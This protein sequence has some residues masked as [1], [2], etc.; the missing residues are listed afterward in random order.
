M[1]GNS[2][3][4]EDNLPHPVGQLSWNDLQSF[5]TK[6]NAGQNYR[7]QFALPSEAQ[8][9][10]ACRAGTTTLWHCGNSEKSARESCWFRG[11]SGGGP[12]PVGQYKANAWGLFDM[13]GNVTEWCADR[14]D[15]D[16]YWQSPVEDP[17]GPQKGNARVHRGGSW[18]D[19]VETSRSAYRG[20]WS[21]NHGLDHFGFRLA[22]SIELPK[23]QA[24]MPSADCV[25]LVNFDDPTTTLCPNMSLDTTNIEASKGASEVAIDSSDGALGSPMSLR[26]TYHTNEKTW[27]Q[28]D[29]V[30]QGSRR[31]FFDLTPYD[32]VSFFVKGDRPGSVGFMVH[33]KAVREGDETWV[34]LGFDYTTEWK[35]VTIDLEPEKLSKLDLR[36]VYG[37]SFGYLGDTSPNVNVLWIDEITCRRKSAGGEAPR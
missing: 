37:F 22:A 35:K 27:V 15:A 20:N 28:A 19:N 26:W 1:G 12:H 24:L 14:Y 34:I 32:S 2:S 30:L 25:L 18:F 9:E 29:V 11:N 3:K 13:H 4:S 21:P 6:L 8:W 10:Y 16:Y 5:L 7:M 17:S 36:R 31:K 23:L 33:A